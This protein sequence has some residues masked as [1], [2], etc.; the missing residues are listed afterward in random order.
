MFFY[1]NICIIIVIVSIYNLKNRNTEK[2][3]N[4]DT[5]SG[6]P[7][8][9]LVLK[10]KKLV[11]PGP[12]KCNAHSPSEDCVVVPKVHSVST[13]LTVKNTLKKI[14]MKKKCL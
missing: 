12:V 10:S 14:I 2:L 11:L 3:K 1:L 5:Y 4:L 6:P 8:N 9:V 7:L 13:E